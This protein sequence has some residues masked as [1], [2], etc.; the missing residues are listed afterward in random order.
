LY[1]KLES[2]L[3]FQHMY[4]MGNHQ[5]ISGHGKRL[6]IEIYDIFIMGNHQYIFGHGNHMNHLIHLSEFIKSFRGW[7]TLW[8]WHDM[9]F[10]NNLCVNRGDKL[11]DNNIFPKFKKL[12]IILLNNASFN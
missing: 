1:M 10:T 2:V 4:I 8:F 6:E 7:A 3:T 11:R 5:Y 12:Y 9:D